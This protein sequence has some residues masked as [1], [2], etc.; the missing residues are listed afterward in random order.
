[1]KEEHLECGS[2]QS[3]DRT[4]EKGFAMSSM[5]SMFEIVQSWRYGKCGEGNSLQNL[6]I[7]LTA[8][9]N[10]KQLIISPSIE[11]S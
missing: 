11:R 2:E 7:I 1:M 9:T 5:D 10:G 3:G 8:E 4:T 6:K